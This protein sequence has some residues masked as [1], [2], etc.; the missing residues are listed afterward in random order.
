MFVTSLWF[1]LSI[2]PS[3]LAAGLHR[4]K[5]P[6]KICTVISL[7]LRSIPDILSDYQD[8]NH[9][10]QMRGIELDK[11]KT[12]LF[13]RLK[14][15]MTIVIPLILSSFSKVNK[16]SSAMELRRFGIFKDKT[17][18]IDNKLNNIDRLFICLGLVQLFITIIYIFF[19]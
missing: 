16:I 13:K 3:Q 15:A 10:M 19:Y 7:G 12:S 17:Y 1:I 4:M 6:Y 9:S 14:Y 18:Y 2:T 8:I 5:V 11:N